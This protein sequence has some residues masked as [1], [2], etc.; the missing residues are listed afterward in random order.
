MQRNMPAWFADRPKPGEGRRQTMRLAIVGKTR[1][2]KST[3]LHRFLS[4]ALRHP[5]A[6]VVLLDGKGCELHHYANLPGVTYYGMDE[7]ARWAAALTAHVTRMA[8]CYRDLVDRGLREAAAQTAGAGL[9]GMCPAGSQDDTM[10][11]WPT[12]R[13]LVIVSSCHLF[14]LSSCHSSTLPSLP[15]DT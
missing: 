5:W 1:S 10:S 3:A 6:G 15:F 8:T 12:H 14:I 11:R 2:G 9:W 4:H 13:H 7:I